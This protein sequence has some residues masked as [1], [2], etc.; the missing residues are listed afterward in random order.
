MGA[1]R[2]ELRTSSLSGTRSN[3]LSYARQHS[4]GYKLTLLRPGSVGWCRAL[5]SAE[6]TRPA[7]MSELLSLLGGTEPEPNARVAYIGA[8]S[9]VC[10][11]I[12]L[13][14]PEP[15][16]RAYLDRLASRAHRKV[17]RCG[18]CRLADDVQPR[19][20]ALIR[21]VERGNLGGSLRRDIADRSMN[22]GKPW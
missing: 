9:Y 7:H 5:L 4:G 15:M 11:T 6:I 20:G 17:Y 18:P 12:A 10:A 22:R 14:A 13:V 3:Q 21:I 16:I 2:F 19:H 8:Q 1:R